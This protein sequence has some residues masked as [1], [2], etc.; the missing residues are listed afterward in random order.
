VVTARG[1]SVTLGGDAG[2]RLEAGGDSMVVILLIEV[3]LAETLTR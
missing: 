3:P 1:F 2:R